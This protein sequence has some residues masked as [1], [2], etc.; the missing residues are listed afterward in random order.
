[1]TLMNTSNNSLPLRYTTQESTIN[2]NS[3]QPNN[4]IPPTINT[5]PLSQLKTNTPSNQVTESY[6]SSYSGPPS[7]TT[8]TV[9]KSNESGTNTDKVLPSNPVRLF[10]DD[11]RSYVLEDYCRPVSEWFQCAQDICKFNR[12]CLVQKK[13]VLNKGTFLDSISPTVFGSVPAISKKSNYIIHDLCLVKC[14]TP[15]CK[16]TKTQ[17]PKMFHHICFMHML[18]INFY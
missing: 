12:E 18:K 5:I 8:T 1:M 4:P 2:C 17:E 14:F 13:K 10:H 6:L 3:T 7:N 11:E 16:N 15:S 9:H